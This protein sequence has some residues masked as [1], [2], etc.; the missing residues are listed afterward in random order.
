MSEIKTGLVMEGGAMRGMF[1]AGVTDVFLEN[2]ITFDGAIGVS[3]GVVFG[4]NFKSKQ[5][6]RVIRYNKRFCKDLRF[7]SWISR[8]FTGDLYNAHFCYDT[9]PNKLDPFDV[10]TFSNNPMKFYMVAT[11]CKTGNP[12]Y[13]ELKNTLGEENTWMRASASMPLVSSVVK[14]NDYHVM[15]GAL[16]DS[17]PLKYFESLGYNRNVLILTQ[18]ADY[19]KKPESHLDLVKL[20]LGKYPKVI[21]KLATRHIDYNE[22]MK[23]IYE[24]ASK[25]EVL[26]IAPKG[27]LPV[28][29][30]DKNPA[31]LESCYQLGRQA[32]IEKLEQV[33]IFLQG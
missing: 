24:K 33:K 11:D 29:R 5:I 22:T 17:I 15:D 14:I 19:I 7:R 31:H 3:A 20:Q 25:N 12:I 13:K 8:I 1:T 30:S 16:S 10:Q 26:V 4:C 32:A 27:T 28:S 6:G 9:I 18:P 23:Y 2:N 21:E